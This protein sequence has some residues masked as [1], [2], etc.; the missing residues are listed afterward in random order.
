MKSSHPHESFSFNI[1]PLKLYPILTEA[2]LFLNVLSEWSSLL[3]DIYLMIYHA[4]LSSFTLSC[5]TSSLH[6][7]EVHTVSRFSVCSCSSY[8]TCI[9][10]ISISSCSLW[11]YH[12]PLAVT[13]FLAH[14]SPSWT[15]STPSFFSFSKCLS[16][17][18][19]TGSQIFTAGYYHY[20]V[21]S[22]T[23]RVIAF[24]S[25]HCVRPSQSG[26]WSCE[27]CRHGTVLTEFGVQW[28][29]RRRNGI[30]TML[31][32]EVNDSNCGYICL[33]DDSAPQEPRLKVSLPLTSLVFQHFLHSWMHTKLKEWLNEMLVSRKCQIT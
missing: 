3:S 15:Y 13:D 16:V 28:R 1:P 4:F 17:L 11:S 27:R 12:P 9:L 18:L 24:Q 26:E 32:R 14:L 6:R 10:L 31:W 8:L 19:S 33:F 22:N 30:V 20:V 23:T 2:F 25:Q 21:S 5:N 7:E 29:R